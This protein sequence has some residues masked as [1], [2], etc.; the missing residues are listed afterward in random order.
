MKIIII[1]SIAQVGVNWIKTYSHPSAGRKV[2]YKDGYVY[3]GGVKKFNDTTFSTIILK[4]D[5]TGNLIQEYEYISQW[6]KNTVL[7]DF[8]VDDTG[9]I[10]AAISISHPDSGE[11]F[12]VIKFKEDGSREWVYR[13]Q[14]TY[15]YFLDTPDKA[16][17]MEIDLRERK[18]KSVILK[19]NFLNLNEFASGIF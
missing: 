2:I 3:T 13:W 16:V 14:V 17:D 18:I 6:Q 8:T 11:D 7:K 12:G 9:N 1:L 19:N 10:Y 5:T 15:G 4:Y